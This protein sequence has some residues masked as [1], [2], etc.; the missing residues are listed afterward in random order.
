MPDWPRDYHPIIDGVIDTDTT[1]Q[2]YPHLPD[3]TSDLTDWVGGGAVVQVNGGP[4]VVLPTNR[5]VPDRLVGLGDLAVQHADTSVR[6]L[7][8]GEL[9]SHYSPTDL[10]GP[11]PVD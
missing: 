6:A 3:R 10:P 4:V 8:G 1:V 2:I 11:P 9:G 5:P 7:P